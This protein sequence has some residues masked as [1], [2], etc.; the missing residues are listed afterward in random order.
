MSTQ[1]ELEIEVSPLERD[2]VPAADRIF[3]LAFGTNF[4]LPDPLR[5]AE[6][7]EMIRSRQL[8][9]PTAV[10][11][12]EVDGEIV[13]SAFA[14][15]WGSFAFFGPLSVHP[16]FWDRG[17]GQR[18]WE[19]RLPLLDRWG[20]THT[21]LFTHPESTKHVHLYQKFGLWPRFLTA[22]TAKP[23]LAESERIV[24]T[25]SAL[26]EG[27]RE[28]LVGECRSLTD[29]IYP[30][31]DLEREIRVVADQRI[32]DVVLIRENGVLAGFAVCHACPGSEAVLE[33]CYVK[34]GAARPGAGGAERLGRLLDACE[35]FAAAR[36]LARLE[37]GVNTA[38][39]D[40][41]STLLQRGHRP[42][43]QGVAMH[44]PNEAGYD[45]PDAFVLDD[46][47]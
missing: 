17:V 22:L 27:D 6:G 5:F 47:R 39:H 37:V 38:R 45:R 4:G 7:S 9:D 24:E 34:F 14:T 46:W 2:D 31:L 42:F 35:G 1:A 16:D 44:R 8:A 20:V 43:A 21:G 26:S 18:L 33:T 3:R 25:R 15:R 10:F 30:G 29:A 40:A 12:A 13:G 11:K 36:G 19:A 28:K 23:V 41:Y 32:G